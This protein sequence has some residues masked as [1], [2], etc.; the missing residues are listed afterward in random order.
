MDSG[1]TKSP[2][3]KSNE[4]AKTK[5]EDSAKTKGHC[6]SKSQTYSFTGKHLFLFSFSHRKLG[7]VCDEIEKHFEQSLSLL[8]QKHQKSKSLPRAMKGEVGLS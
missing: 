1:K 7:S 2:N 6:R 8:D 4:N 3:L 5:M